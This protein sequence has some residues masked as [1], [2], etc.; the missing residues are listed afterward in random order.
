MLKQD[1]AH[2][3]E[4]ISA[5][6]LAGFFLGFNTSQQQIEQALLMLELSPDD[7]ILL[8]ELQE[9]IV[10]VQKSLQSIGFGQINPLT[11]S[12]NKLLQAVRLNY[13]PFETL[14]SDL[15][16]LAIDDI[17]MVVEKF[18]DGAD[19]CVLMSRLPRICESIDAIAEADEMHIES[20]IRDALL[21]LDP[22]ME[23]IETSI[24]QSDT[25]I[26]L[27][28]QDIPDEEELSAYGVEEGDDFIFFRA[29]SAPLE[30]RASYWRG[31]VDRMLRLALKMNDQAG[32][33]VDPNQLAAAVYIHDAGMAL[34]PLEL[35]NSVDELTQEQ[36]E[37][38]RHHP[39]TG[40]ELMR[41]MKN[42]REAAL[43]VIQHHEQVDGKG[44]PYGLTE[45]EMCEGAKILAIVD[46]V[47]AR[48][49]ERAHAM[50]LKRPLLRA[51]IELG[52]YAGVQ[53]SEK[54]VDVFKEVFQEMR[55]IKEV[56]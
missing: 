46:A 55:K 20:A 27:F 7:D 39:V 30:N 43:I 19:R 22:G 37:L 18:I 47:D 2:Q 56:N 45:R 44:Y 28:S 29:L 38:V 40:Y 36:R 35:I 21:L 51:A 16:L 34:L 6:A 5:P 52:K 9:N 24:T 41:Y 33:P 42:W 53:F 11:I 32:R 14:L 12:L 49:H 50:L 54:W 13:I 26:N 23:I 1:F 17:K 3:F 10:S 4:I 31:R 25:L 15:V 8:H 48:T